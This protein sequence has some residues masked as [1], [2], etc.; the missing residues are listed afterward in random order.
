[1]LKISLIIPV[2]NVAK[3]VDK[4][5]LSCEKQD[6]LSDEY[7]IIVVND[8]TKD[9]SLSVVERVAKDYSNIRILSQ[10]NQGL[11]MARNNGL[12]VAK[13][14][15]MWFIDS[16]D[17]IE[18]NCLSEICSRL[19]G[20]I[21]LLQLQYRYAYDDSSRNQNEKICRIDVP[22]AGREQ[23]LRGGIPAP[24]PFTIYRRQF[25][26]DNRLRFYPGIYHEDSEFKPRVL[27]LA[28]SIRSYNEVVYNY[29]QR[30]EG[31]IMSTFRLKN[32]KDIL[33][34]NNR[35]LD[36]VRK[37]SVESHCRKCF[38]QNIALNLNT[39][40][41]GLRQLPEETKTEMMIE[42]I[43]NKHQFRKMFSSGI[44][45]YQVEAL[46]FCLNVRLGLA[47]HRLMR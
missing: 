24:A 31:S 36:F 4:C 30:S 38:Y 22:I 46:I 11:S 26:I 33:F 47:V 35:L 5:L 7:E 10:E 2:Y 40:L 37:E 25:L 41:F 6:I 19:D 3:Y 45:K 29:Y 18:E 42:L 13:G 21:D 28:K 1:M 34:V 17:W 9:N 39:L 23:M 43:E 12:D 44:L 32:G 8:G 14:E 16:D 27:Y 15:Y 20:K